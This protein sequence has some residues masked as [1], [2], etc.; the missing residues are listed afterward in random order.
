MMAS[1][2]LVIFPSPIG[3]GLLLFP[4]EREEKKKDI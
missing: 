2:K 3:L 1:Q 4:G